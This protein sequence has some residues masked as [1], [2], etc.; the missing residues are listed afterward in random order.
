LVVALAA[1][2]R[3][4]ADRAQEDGRADGAA[5]SGGGGVVVGRLA[6]GCS[7]DAGEGGEVTRALGRDGVLGPR[8]DA[9]R[10]V[11]G[12]DAEALGVLLG[13]DADGAGAAARGRQGG[14]LAEQVGELV[15]AAG[16]QL[17]HTRGGGGRQVA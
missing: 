16:A 12:G 6:R 17:G 4:Q 14:A 7:G 1:A 10:E 11:G 9:D 2:A 3:L 13:A 8:G 15:G 5:L